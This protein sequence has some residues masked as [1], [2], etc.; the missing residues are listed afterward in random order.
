M[1]FLA[2]DA[3]SG[4]EVALKSLHPLL[5]TNAEEMERIRENFVVA[6]NPERR[7]A[8]IVDHYETCEKREI[9]VISVAPCENAPP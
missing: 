6:S 3:V 7:S 4:V 1:V 5:K 8:E 2:R 9:S